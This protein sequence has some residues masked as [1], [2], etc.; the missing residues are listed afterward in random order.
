MNIFVVDYNPSTCAEYHVDK[1]I[2]KMP[3]ETAQM[4][5]FAYYHSD[6]WKQEVP[7]LLMKFSKT[8]DLHPCSIWIRESLE[9]FI[10]TCELGIQLVK[11]YRYRYNPVKHQRALDIFHWCL[12][13]PPNLPI[14]GI[15]PFALA[16]PDVYKTSSVVDSYRNYYRGDKSD[17]HKWKN[18]QKP[19]WI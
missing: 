2:V 17:I 7:E 8:H 12:Q 13:N 10:W 9:N 15:T 18:R 5:S 3:T 4:L 11:E 14:K 6:L 16:I 1:H 19:E